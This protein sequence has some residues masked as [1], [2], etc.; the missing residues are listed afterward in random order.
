[1]QLDAGLGTLALSNLLDNAARY[2][3]ADSPITVEV[4]GGSG[5]LPCRVI[6]HGPGLPPALAGGSPGVVPR[7]KGAGS[8]EGGFGLA[9]AARVAGAHGGRFAAS[10]DGVRTILALSLPLAQPAELPGPGRGAR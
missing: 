9:L 4:E 6:N 2:A 7:S 8:E 1:M 3:C 10:Q 5:A